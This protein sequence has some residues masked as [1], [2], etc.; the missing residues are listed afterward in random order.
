MSRSAVPASRRHEWMSLFTSRSRRALTCALKD[1]VRRARPRFARL[2]V[3]V[4]SNESDAPRAT[5]S[6]TGMTSLH[7]RT[8]D[9]FPTSPPYTSRK[10]VVTRR[11]PFSSSDESGGCSP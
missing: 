5:Y 11:L 9:T 8:Q 7:G 10:S 3:Q 1:D 2:T 4:G 6:T